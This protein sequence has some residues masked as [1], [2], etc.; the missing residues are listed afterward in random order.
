MILF[1]MIVHL[2]AVVLIIA[3]WR[4]K[5]ISL[6]PSMIPLVC[7]LPLWGPVCAAVV[8]L[9]VRGGEKADQEAGTGRFGITDEVYRSIR[10]DESSVSE[11]LPIEDVLM[12]GTPEQRRSLLLSVLHSGPDPF[13]RPL[14]TAGVNDDT[15]VVHYAVTALVE[16][17]REYTQRLSKM[18]ESLR[19]HPND[20]AV[21]MEAAELDEEYLQSGIPENNERSERLSHCRKI[22]EQLLLYTSWQEKG[23]DSGGLQQ[24][25]IQNGDCQRILLLQKLGGIC[26]MQEDARGADNAA[27]ALMEEAPGNEAGYLMAVRARSLAGDGRGLAVILETLRQKGIYIS[28]EGR[29]QLEF[30]ESEAI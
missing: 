6:A 29:A 14:R 19:E 26:L 7:L 15:E 21:L 4:F 25:K 16:L 8:E 5:L 30:W 24:G 13:V 22:L 28:P 2:I 23:A 1:L 11:I 3:A 18:E 9:H 12:D 20:P 17:R 10:M 27:A